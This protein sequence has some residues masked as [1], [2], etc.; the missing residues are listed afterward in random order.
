M[1][2]LSLNR[3]LAAGRLAI[4]LTLLAR[5]QV[6]RPLAGAQT[7]RG[8]VRALARGVGCRD[9]FLG[10]V[11]LGAPEAAA[12]RLLAVAAFVD[13]NDAVAIGAE[14][15]DLPRA[16]PVLAAT[17]FGVALLQLWLAARL[18]RA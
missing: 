15:G 11:G 6:V 16:A 1:N 3:A 10:A 7:D 9:V 18:N 12:A 4:G 5:P 8:A 17:A 2:D 14:R 13:V